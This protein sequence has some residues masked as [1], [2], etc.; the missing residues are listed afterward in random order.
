MRP[1][2]ALVAASRRDGL[3]LCARHRKSS[4]PCRRPGPFSGC[5]VPARSRPPRLSHRT[6][7]GT[8]ARVVR[9]SGSR[10]PHRRHLDAQG[11]R[12]G[13]ESGTRTHC[14]GQT[15]A[16]RRSEGSRRRLSA[17]K[18]CQCPFTQTRTRKR[19]TN[20]AAN[21]TISTVRLR[22]RRARHA[23][24]R[25]ALAPCRTDAGRGRPSSLAS[26]RASG[27]STVEFV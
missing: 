26:Q 25:G 3:S 8:P 17:G 21:N 24:S 15:D 18:K 7:R 23:R 12:D 19:K 11:N 9:R 16:R 5:G 22:D 13:G 4:A 14:A 27:S 10:R 2:R 20:A 1:S 6:R